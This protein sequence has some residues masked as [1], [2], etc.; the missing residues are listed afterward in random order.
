MSVK[1]DGTGNSEF[2]EP[3]CICPIELI[4]HETNMIRTLAET[5]IEKLA[6]HMDTA[7][8]QAYDATKITANS[9][10][11]GFVTGG[12]T[13]AVLVAPG[14]SIKVRYQDMGEVTMRCV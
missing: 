14:D 10:L 1:I 11:T 8:L 7:E 6:E 13:A 9:A 2:R 12:V 3:D 5:D 4:L